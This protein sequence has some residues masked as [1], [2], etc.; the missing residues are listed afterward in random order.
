MQLRPTEKEYPSLTSAIFNSLHALRMFIY[1]S[2]ASETIWVRSISLKMI[3]NFFKIYFF[4]EADLMTGYNV[5]FNRI[6]TEIIT[7]MKIFIIRKDRS[8]TQTAIWLRS[9]LFANSAASFRPITAMKNKRA[10]RPW[11]AHLSIQANTQ[12]FNFEIWVTFDQGQRMTLTF[13][14]HSTSLTHLAE[15][16]KQLWDLRLQ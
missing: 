6:L 4:K 15:C 11:I 13:D 2:W 10:K 9:T 8:Q 14:T 5:C 12:T 16:F 3:M 1:S 7:T